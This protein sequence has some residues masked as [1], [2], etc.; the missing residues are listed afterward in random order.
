MTTHLDP[1]VTQ[2]V[3]VPLGWVVD[4]LIHHSASQGIPILEMFVVV[5]R[6]KPMISVR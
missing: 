6:E 1:L 5:S 4:T 2:E 3:K